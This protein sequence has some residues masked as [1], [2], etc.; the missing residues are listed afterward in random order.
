MTI[1]SSSAQAAFASP[2]RL[3][4][5]LVSSRSTQPASAGSTS[6]LTDA[7]G[8]KGSL[9]CW[10]IITSGW[11]VSAKGSAPLVISYAMTPTA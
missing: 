6:G 5:S 8:R 10:S 2:G 11:S 4:V 9:T 1:S 7:S 3:P